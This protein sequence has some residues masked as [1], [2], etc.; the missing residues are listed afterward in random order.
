M[1]IAIKKLTN[2]TVLFIIYA[3]MK[4]KIL[5]IKALWREKKGFNLDRENIGNQYIFVQNLEYIHL[6]NKIHN[7]SIY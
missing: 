6:G 4:M 5:R 2:T 7:T 1:K 3:V